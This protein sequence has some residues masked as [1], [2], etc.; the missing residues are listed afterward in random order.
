MLVG[1][2]CVGVCGGRCCLVEFVLW[3]VVDCVCVIV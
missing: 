3:G 2:C 1:C